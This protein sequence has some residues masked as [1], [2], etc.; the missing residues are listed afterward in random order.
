[1][2]RASCVA[3]VSA[4]IAVPTTR[5]ARMT[6]MSSANESTSSSLWEMKMTAAPAR[7][8][9]RIAAKRASASAGTSTAVGSSRM[10]MRASR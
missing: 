1:M 6:V 9:S 2:S 5:P 4:G 10:M 3:V 8:N 7:V